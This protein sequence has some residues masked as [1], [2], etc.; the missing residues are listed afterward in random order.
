MFLL[1]FCLIFFPVGVMFLYG[2]KESSI[3][4]CSKNHTNFHMYFHL[5]S[6]LAACCA[7]L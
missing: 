3:D 1:H 4:W 6:F 5:F 7:F 2:D